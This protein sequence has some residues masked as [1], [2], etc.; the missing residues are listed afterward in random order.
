TPCPQRP[1]K[2]LPPFQ[3]SVWVNTRCIRSDR[4]SVRAKPRRSSSAADYAG[5]PHP[6]PEVAVATLHRTPGAPDRRR[7]L[8]SAVRRMPRGC[9]PAEA[10]QVRHDPPQSTP[11][12]HSRLDGVLL[13]PHPRPPCRGRLAWR[14]W[15]G[16]GRRAAELRGRARAALL[17]AG[18]RRVEVALRDVA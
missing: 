4:E 5:A 15:R 17:A 7:R 1:A 6:M 18:A 16:A 14:E 13:R 2:L 12:V 11:V 8:S 10:A 9:A 3:P